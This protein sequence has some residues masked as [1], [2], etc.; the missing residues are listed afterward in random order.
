MRVAPP[1]P[2]NSDQYQTKG[3]AEKAVRKNIKTTDMGNDDIQGMR[4]G[5]RA[6]K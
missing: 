2:G 4:L 3:L 6:Q 5:Q 1:P